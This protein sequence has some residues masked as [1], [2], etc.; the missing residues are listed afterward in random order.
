MIHLPR[1]GHR[2][3]FACASGA[4]NYTGDGYWFEQPF[5]ILGLLDTRLLTIIPKSLTLDAQPGNGRLWPFGSVRLI[6]GGMLNAVGLRNPGLPHWIKHLY[7]KAVAAGYKL[8]ASIAPKTVAEAVTMAKLLDPLALAGVEVNPTCPNVDHPADEADLVLAVADHTRHDVIAKLAHP[9]YKTT[10]PRLDGKIACFDLINAVKW[11][12]VFPG[13]PSPLAHLGGG[14]V[15]GEPIIPFAR[16]A[17]Q[18]A[19]DHLQ[20]QVMSGGGVN[21]KEEALIRFYMGAGG[22]TLGSVITRRPHLVNAIV[23]DTVT[24]IGARP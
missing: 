6:P 14:A 21:S 18:W 20:T 2:F 3:H 22:V 4:L 1:S 7:P 24:A 8:I 12:Y 16:A 17:L 9:T 13:T 10:A 15:S 11:E 19:K 5:R 23:Q